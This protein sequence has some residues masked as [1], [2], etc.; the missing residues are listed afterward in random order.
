LN[1]LVGLVG[2]GRWGANVLRDLVALGADVCVADPD[3]EARAGA[4]AG[5]AR[6]VVARTTELPRCDG[7][8]VVTPAPTHRAVCEPLLAHGVPVFVEKPPCT[9]VADVDALARAGGG[10]L[11]VMHKWR[12]HPGIRALAELARSGRLG[13]PVTLETTRTG[14]GTLPPAVDVLWHLATH[15]LSIALAVLGTVPPVRSARAERD[16]TGRITW[17]RA[18]M[19]DGAGTTHRMTTAVGVADRVRR[20]VV[21]G[22]GASAVL[23]HPD[24]PSVR[25]Q[26]PGADDELLPVD[27]TMPLLA[28]LAAFLDHLGGGPPPVSDIATALLVVQRLA[29][30][31][32]AAGPVPA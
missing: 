14:P 28:E 1:P 7:Y 23:D 21:A 13:S 26:R 15:D 3:P 30:L 25:I 19:A 4:V 9:D 29:E 10:R 12:Y 18:T 31:E 16:A 6:V 32:R 2:C 8:V 27:R 22:S 20:V 17:C 5:G 11:F 24:A